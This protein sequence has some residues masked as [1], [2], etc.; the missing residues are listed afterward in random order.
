Q[1]LLVGQLKREPL[2]R[3]RALIAG[4]IEP[5][6]A[7]A[8]A[9]L[10]QAARTEEAA[11]VRAAA[12]ERLAGLSPAPELLELALGELQQPYSYATFG[13]AA[14]LLV[15]QDAE[16]ARERLRAFE[17]QGDAA[18]R[19]QTALLRAWL[20]LGERARLIEWARDAGR[21]VLLREGCVRALSQER[22]LLRSLLNDASFRVRRAAI[23]GLDAR[24][25][26]VLRPRL[27]SPMMPEVIAVE[28]A[29]ARQPK[30]G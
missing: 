28:A 11:G 7:D 22:E 17:S 8:R 20:Q 23:D 12:L 29:L 16:L 2:G 19:T 24:D 18:G 21:P 27:G 13:A 30:G 26:D 25:A 3:L 14:N 5:S 15:V 9:A 10:L 4:A 6:A 1:E